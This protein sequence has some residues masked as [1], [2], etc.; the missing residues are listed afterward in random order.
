MLRTMPAPRA[1][2]LAALLAATAARPGEARADEV[3]GVELRGIG[4]TEVHE[5]AAR[6]S[7]DIDGLLARVTMATDLVAAEGLPAE[8]R[9]TFALPREAVPIGVDVKDGARTL[10]AI[11]V[12]ADS[13]VSPIRDPGG[14]KQRPDLALLRRVAWPSRFRTEQTAGWTRWELTVYPVSARGATARVTWLV[15]VRYED[16]RLEVRLPAH[17]GPRLADATVDLTIAGPAGTRALGDVAC[18]GHT[19]AK[20]AAAQARFSCGPLRG[21]ELVVTAVPTFVD[22][23]PRA[24]VAHT[25]LDG[26]TTVVGVEVVVPPAAPRKGARWER[27]VLVVDTSRSLGDAGTRTTRDLVRAA[28]A[29][30][31]AATKL[32]VIPFDRTATPLLGGLTKGTAAVRAKVDAALKAR[33]PKNGSDLVGALRAA[34]RL[35]ADAERRDP[36]PR[37]GDPTALLLIVSDGLTPTSVSVDEALTALGE[38]ITATTHVAAILIHPEGTP[39]PPASAL[40]LG[41]L[42]TRAGGQTILLP[43]LVAPARIAA[44]IKAIDRPLP[45]ATPELELGAAIVEGLELPSTIAP[46]SGLV[47]TGRARG[48]L[49]AAIALTG[50]RRAQPV[51]IQGAPAPASFV[52]AVAALWLASRDVED[53]VGPADRLDPGTTYA[54]DV[55][56]AARRALVTLSARAGLASED[57]ALVVVDPAD[58][59]GALRLDAARRFG[60]SVFQRLA[61]P[62][63]RVPGREL[64]AQTRASST[65]RRADPAPLVPPRGLAT[66]ELDLPI[67]RRIV[68]GALLPLAKTCYDQTLRGAPSFGGSLELRLELSRGELTSAT[69]TRSTVTGQRGAA[70]ETCVRDAAQGIDVPR[71]AVGDLPDDIT[72]A[73]YP[74]TFRVVGGTADVVDEKAAPAATPRDPLEGL[75]N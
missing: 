63:E 33:R 5:R 24:R 53:L 75:G 18:A 16:G 50:R 70:L 42:A 10:T 12:D 39:A 7:V 74:L 26:A 68:R 22:D 55:W 73:R 41:Q 32:E 20:S 36:S 37:G 25:A 11:G 71:V 38:S 40:A 45:L 23:R 64:V 1:L 56:E 8:A 62:P 4:D 43:D 47:A 29:S 34:G 30:L 27:A 2:V 48:P 13:A 9:L 3:T 61:P 44:T 46:G 52:K 19:V 59:F 54:P 17:V 51:A 6:L 14:L 58:P 66:G 60:P 49:P 69:I 21:K 28:L 57:V 65:P 67:V 35:L 72:I 15:P 31:P